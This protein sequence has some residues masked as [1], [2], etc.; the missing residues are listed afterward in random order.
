MTIHDRDLAE[1]YHTT[2]TGLTVGIGSLVLL[3]S[4]GAH[5]LLQCIF[6]CNENG[7][8]QSGHGE[9]VR[10]SPIL[11]GFLNH[12]VINATLDIDLVLSLYFDDGKYL[13][14]VP[15]ENGL[16]SY[17][18]TTRYGICPITAGGLRVWR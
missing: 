12:R 5:V 2:L 15:E 18:V 14:I 11:F 8:V 6:E 3:F 1:F 13:R 7:I 17:V 10:S 9:D 4:S 16:E